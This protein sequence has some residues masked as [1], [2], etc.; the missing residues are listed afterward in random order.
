[1]EKFFKK[2]TRIIAVL[3][4]L[5][6]S[7]LPF[8]FLH[9][10]L[11]LI[12][13]GREFYL[14]E[15][16]NSG[17]VLYKNVYNIYGPFSYQFNA[18]LFK[19]F[20]EHYNTLYFAGIL[21]SLLI[22][23]IMFLLSREFT[24]KI[25]SFL[26]AL[27]T[28]FSLVFTT[29]LY[30]SNITYAFAMVYALSAFLLSLL[31]LIKYIKNGNVA[32]AFISCFFAGFSIANKYEFGLYIVILAYC[33]IFLK[34]AGIKNVLKSL[35]YFC[36]IPFICFAILLL[37]E[38]NYDDIK[39]TINMFNNM[40]N[41]PSLKLFYS[42][43]GVFFNIEYL[44]GL[45]QNNGI[46]AVFG[47]LPLLNL[48]L[49]IIKYKQI[50]K[51]KVLFAFILCS[52]AACA[53]AFFFL[54]VNHM[55]VFIFPVCI[56]ASVVLF[57][58]YNIKFIS[59]LLAAAVVLFA[60][61]DFSSLKYKNYLLE[62]PKGRIYTFKKDGEPVKYVSDFIIANTNIADKVVIMPEGSFINFITGRKG[63]NFFYNLSPLFYTDV[64]GEEMILNH[65]EKN[66][67][68]YFVIL[69]INNIEY[70][71]SF[72]G[73]DYAQNFYE[74]IVNNYNLI[75]EKNGIKIFKRKNL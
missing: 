40:L 20:G 9:Q 66:M 27:L 73:I 50:Y 38:L 57:E 19:I 10:G 39:Y 45:I 75:E 1:M 44:K 55:G 71:K 2:D 29:F 15:Q 33:L 8:F 36:I 31:F 6:L 64:F 32:F 46:F 59:L 18:V 13:T 35:L 70:G 23:I 12:D 28:M 3:I 30:N 4:V 48:I 56:L 62:T 60:A 52:F 41:A 37:Q 21:N 65:F 17:G 11:L 5:F 68:E 72:F 49:F 53:K 63:D 14:P 67:P 26:I 42:T 61:E 74:M 34:P 25:N 43:F 69:P 58:R 47:V 51:D 16:I 7:A 54:N 24:N 22:T